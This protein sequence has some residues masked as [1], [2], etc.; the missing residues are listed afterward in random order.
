MLCRQR[1]DKAEE[2]TDIRPTTLMEFIAE[3]REAE[4]VFESQLPPLKVQF[5]LSDAESSCLEVG[6]HEKVAGK[7]FNACSPIVG[8]IGSF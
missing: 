4:K 6:P 1:G 8:P 3:L 7:T 5:Q 2:S